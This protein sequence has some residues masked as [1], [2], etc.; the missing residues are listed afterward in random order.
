MAH[1]ASCVQDL[2]AAFGKY[3]CLHPVVGDRLATREHA[4]SEVLAVNIR[5]QR[6]P[7]YFAALNA[8]GG[9]L[10]L[11]AG[12]AFG[13]PNLPSAETLSE[14]RAQYEAEVP[15]TILELQPYR[16]ES[17]SALVRADGARGAATLTNLNP[18]ANSWY[19]LSIDW[20]A[21]GGRSSYHLE[22]PLPL[23]PPLRLLNGAGQA[24]VVVADDGFLCT[25][26]VNDARGALDEAGDSGLPYAP[27]CGGA[28]YL[29][30]AVAGHR[31]S[32][33]RVT[34]FLR[35]RVWGGDQMINFIKEEFYRDAFL[36]KGVAGRAVPSVQTSPPGGPQPAAM[37]PEQNARS[38][39]TQG[40]AL[41]LAVP[42]RE[43]Q[44]GQWYAVRDL[45][46]ITVSVTAPQYIANS[47]RLGHEAS[48][49]PL[50]RVE[51]DALVYLVAFDLQRLDLHFVL[52]TD[53]PRVDWSE[54]PPPSSRDPRLPGP[55][56]IAS[57]A[58]LVTNGM[59]SPADAERTVATFAGGFKRSHGA[60]RV[61][62][63]AEHNHGS[64]YGFIE[65]GV[66]FSKLQP[67]LATALV[68]DDGAVDL[69]TWRLA[70]DAMLPRIRYARQNGVPLIEYDAER[71]AGEPGALVNLWG[72]G[73]WSGSAEEVL[74]T[75]RAGLCLQESGTHRFL[76]Y[77]YF[78]AATPSAMA[79]VFQAYNCRY[80][81]H[82]DMN[83]L[84]HTYLALYVHRGRQL[85][86]EHLIE[87]MQAVDRSAG[88]QF[89]PRFLSF[90]DDRDFFYLTR[91]REVTP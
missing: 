60:F 38:V 10:P 85:L 76:L 29:R 21:G 43:L 45:A 75:L 64:H 81:L 59:V 58:P 87:G 36:E 24:L 47:I 83:A 56:G 34:D 72:P 31:T 51:S 84:E 19:L 78:S 6:W 71:G 48:V 3:A 27:V 66:I 4:L 26:W 9:A 25:L 63:L 33:E 73:N 39:V 17:R 82:L 14:Q 13:E 62:P 8:T 70:D 2:G 35:D 69:R 12:S 18:Y 53:H 23:R 22:N 54:R 89:A 90:P 41:D 67:G 55:D 42:A 88:N 61:G 15:K 77:A 30:N 74:R 46:G 80:A 7:V 86:V 91:R 16:S 57:A 5:K 49:N 28:L 44:P 1:A 32:L 11:I 68:M 50:D 37:D 65:Q 52:G 40:L 79:R 20:P